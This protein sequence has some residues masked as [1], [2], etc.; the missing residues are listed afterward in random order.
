M[1]GALALAPHARWRRSLASLAVRDYRHYFGG[2]LVSITGNWMQTVGEM[3]LL[4]QLTH[5]GVAVGSAAALQ[6]VPILLFGVYGGVLVDR[7]DRRRVL[8]ATQFALMVPALALGVATATGHVTVAVVYCCIVIRGAVIAIDNPARQAFVFELVGRDRIVNAVSLNSV[9]V[10]TARVLGPAVAGALIAS[11]G[12]ASCFLANA[13]TY[14]V[15][16]V[17]LAT[18]GRPVAAGTDRPDHRHGKVRE[19]VRDVRNH[20]ELRVPLTML[21]VVGTLTL[22]FQV[23]L[24]L[25]ASRTWHGGAST[26]AELTAA[27]GAGSVAGAIGSAGRHKV[28]SAV[29]VGASALFGLAEIAAALAPTLWSQAAAFAVVGA[30]SVTFSSGINAWLQLAAHPSVRGRVMA[31]YSVVLLGSTP[32]GA[33]LIGLAAQMA[34]PRVAMG[35]GAVAAL[36]AAAYGHSHWTRR[37]HVPQETG[38]A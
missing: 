12:I 11:I 33:P 22:N 8:V 20:R 26:F 31:V 15:M 24:P 3:W 37:P 13:C 32:I 9:T 30:A 25:L 38:A 27:L 18:I 21:A 16:V 36:G 34:G 5:S 1:S 29:V 6:F 28:S 7:F 4:V 23:L 35:V 10:H 19:I 17:V 2:Q 14:V